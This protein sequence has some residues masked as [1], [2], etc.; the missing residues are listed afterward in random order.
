[1]ITKR[2]LRLVAVGACVLGLVGLAGQKKQVERPFTGSIQL[3]AHFIYELDV[4]GEWVLVGAENSGWGT[5]SHIGLFAAVGHMIVDESGMYLWGTMTAANDDVLMWE[6]FDPITTYII[7]G[8]G[9]FAHATGTGS[10]VYDEMVYG[11]FDP[12]TG[13]QIAHSTGHFEGTLTY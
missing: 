8:T 10:W 2:M 1:M 11:P 6:A 13:T 12:D 3:E 4:D 7:D 5:A 9:R